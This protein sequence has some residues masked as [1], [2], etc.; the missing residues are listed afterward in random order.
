MA[1][2]EIKLKKMLCI[3]IHSEQYNNESVT[4]NKNLDLNA[5]SKLQVFDL[6]SL[7]LY[8]TQRYQSCNLGRDS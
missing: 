3:S 5:D 4:H 1:D 6:F 7:P 2:V 8:Y